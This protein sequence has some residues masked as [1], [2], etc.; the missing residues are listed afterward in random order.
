MSSYPL[1]IGLG[2]MLLPSLDSWRLA[3]AVPAVFSVL[4]LMAACFTPGQASGA[5]RM[6]P[7]NRLGPGVLAPLM[8][9]A[10][11]WTLLNAGYAVMLGF[12][13][14]F[15]VQHGMAAAAAGS[16]TSIGA[17]VTVVLTPVGGWVTGRLGWPLTAIG[18]CLL[19]MA[20]ALLALAAGLPPIFMLLLTAVGLGLCAGP[21]MTLPGE[22]LAPR[23][24]ALGMGLLYAVYYGGMTVLPPLAGLAGDAAASAAAPI[25]V[26]A[27]FCAV[28]ILCVLAYARL[29]QP[30]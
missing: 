4:G 18:L 9:V 8:A 11:T 14:A 3:M 24:R 12:A 22:I 21:I 19:T 25:V 2:L 20:A 15:F 26:G 29:R 6:A 27:G 10:L 1:G 30:V 16:L 17:F 7:P 13:P 28:A 23:H 5:E